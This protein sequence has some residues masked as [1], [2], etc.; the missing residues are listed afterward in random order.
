MVLICNAR[1]GHGGVGKALPKIRGLLEERGLDYEVRYTQGPQD[2]TAIARTALEQGFKFLVAVGGDGTVHEVVNGMVS[3]DKPVRD[4]AVMGVVAA[5]T[6]SDFIKTFGLPAEMPAHAVAH[7][8]GSEAFPIDIGKITYTQ[9]GATVV[10]YFANVAE[11]GVGAEA[12]WRA[13]RLPQWFG[14]MKYLIAFWLAM[15]GFKTATASVDLVDRTYEGRLNNLVVA[16]GQYFGGGMKIAPRAAPTDGLLDIQI[17]H[18]RKREAISLLPKVYKGEHVPHEDI[19]EAKR[20]RLSITTD[21]ALRIEADG[22]VLGYTPAT[23]EIVR[24][25]IKLKV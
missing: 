24:D 18:A 25:A 2:A 22:E 1:A 5:G 17:E 21:R 6:G 15:R 7:L 13:S 9:D 23:F 12:V 3:D 16:N 14:P 11:A 20:V 19:F 8:D 10:R 4:D